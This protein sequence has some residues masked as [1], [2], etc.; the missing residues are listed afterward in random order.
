MPKLAGIGVIGVGESFVGIDKGAV[1]VFFVLPFLIIYLAYNL[2]RDILTF[3]ELEDGKR[4]IV[5]PSEKRRDILFGALKLVA[6]LMLFFL[7]IRL[8]ST[9]F[10]FG[11]GAVVIVSSGIIFAVL[12]G[13]D[14]LKR[15]LYVKESKEGVRRIAIKPG[16]KFEAFYGILKLLGVMMLLV[17]VIILG[18]SGVLFFKP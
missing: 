2:L 1:A 13:T 10:S 15:A 9:G 18:L 12:M 7:M 6:A 16:E 8:Y 3:E 5:I 14:S 11:S 4:R 17:L